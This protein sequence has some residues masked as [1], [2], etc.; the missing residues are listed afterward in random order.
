MS[1][2]RSISTSSKRFCCICGPQMMSPPSLPRSS[3]CAGPPQS[4]VDPHP[5]CPPRAAP[6]G[7]RPI[8]YEALSL[9]RAG[10]CRCRD[11]VRIQSQRKLTCASIACASSNWMPASPLHLFHLYP[12]RSRLLNLEAA[13]SLADA[14]GFQLH[15]SCRRCLTVCFQLNCSS[16]PDKAAL[17]AAQR[18]GHSARV[19]SHLFRVPTRLGPSPRRNR[20]GF[21]KLKSNLRLHLGP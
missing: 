6:Q 2:S 1:P 8:S 3:R 18:P 10:W 9:P 11:P 12:H 15:R 4:P 14:L 7:G 20:Q 5:S 13:L 19:A 16:G 21:M 17:T